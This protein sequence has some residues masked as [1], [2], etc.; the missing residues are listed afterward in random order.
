MKNIIVIFLLLFSFNL[1]SQKPNFLKE[2]E[3]NVFSGNAP[4]N[5]VA[6]LLP[7]SNDDCSGAITLTVNGSCYIDS[8]AGA[9]TQVGENLIPCGTSTLTETVWYR[10][11]A[12]S[13]TM[14]VQLNLIRFSGS[15]V[16]WSPGA[17]RSAI[18]QTNS[19]LPTTPISCQ[20]SNSVGTGDGIIVNELTGLT[21][22]STYYIQ[23]GY[24]TGS[25]SN[26][27]P[28]YCIRLGDQ[29]TPDCNTCSNP[30]GPACGFATTPTVSQ[31]VNTCLPYNQL[32]YIEGSTSVSQCY[33]FYAVNT[34]VSFGIIV[35]STCQSGNVTNF[36]YNLY[37][38]GCISPVQS[39]TLS[40]LTF[41]G[42][43]IG[44]LY[45]FCFSFT[46][47][48]DCYHTTYYPYFV[49]AA[50]LPV[51]LLYFVGEDVGDE[52]HLSWSTASEINNDHF[53]L[54]YS[55][56][57]VSYMNIGSV[58]GAGNSSLESKYHYYHE[59]KCD[60]NVFY[61]KLLQ[62]DF[63]GKIK[64]YD[65]IAIKC[66]KKFVKEPI[67]YYNILTQPVDKNYEGFRITIFNDGTIGKTIKEPN[68]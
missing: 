2:Y 60:S 49:G 4:I 12:T 30:C 45:R 38:S 24:R 61:Y 13:T 66:L 10:F 29:F 52:I 57:D 19:C 68:N 53:S 6:A 27:T 65:P 26:L 18:Y 8:T 5:R 37:N 50:Q 51:E 21:V 14:W 11:V 17:W 43:T 7:P 55:E 42:L 1:Y 35:N 39:G 33:T 44:M 67:M 15:G 25:G 59:K 62:H 48:S 20:T 40:N 54:S 58:Q 63:D 9:T 16:T 64:E 41:S 32:P 28:T 22:G 23:V 36:T 47:P 56:D 34:T 46:T 31:V 3:Y